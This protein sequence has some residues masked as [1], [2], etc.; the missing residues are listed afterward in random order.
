MRSVGLGRPR[1]A[2]DVRKRRKPS[3]P[4]LV[5]LSELF[6]ITSF[7]EQVWRLCDGTRSI[8]EISARC[9]RASNHADDP[10]TLARVVRA[11]E[12]LAAKRLIDVDREARGDVDDEAF[13]WMG[14]EQGC[15]GI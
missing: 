15:S 7:E 8:I 9:S 1:R 3:G 14:S 13:A 11:I 10:E 2:W 5:R 12:E 4:V 6:P